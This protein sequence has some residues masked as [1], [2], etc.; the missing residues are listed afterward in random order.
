MFIG[1]FDVG[2]VDI[3]TF[4]CLIFQNT[5]NIGM[6]ILHRYLFDSIIHLLCNQQMGLTAYVWGYCDN[7]LAI[8]RQ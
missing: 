2:T 3:H 7:A 6:L 4:S 5:M 8:A 1:I